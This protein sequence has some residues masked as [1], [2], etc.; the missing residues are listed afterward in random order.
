M[1][2][3]FKRKVRTFEL[4]GETFEVQNL[5]YGERDEITRLTQ[6]IDPLSGSMDFDFKRYANLLNLKAIKSWTLK[7]EDG[8]ELPI[9]ED[10]INNLLDPDFVDELFKHIDV[11]EVQDELQKKD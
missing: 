5:S 2:Y 6:R 8:S 11:I 7:N 1:S 9:T 3:L 10:T 4:H